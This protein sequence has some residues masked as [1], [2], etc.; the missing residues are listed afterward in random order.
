MSAV[1]RSFN[2]RNRQPANQ[3][4]D[5]MRVTTAASNRPLMDGV[6]SMVAPSLRRRMVPPG[7]LTCDRDGCGAVS[8]TR[9]DSTLVSSGPMI[10]R[11][12]RGAAVEGAS[13]TR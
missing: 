7:A 6:N 1:A 5:R 9:G 10:E 12:S 2:P 3:N 11:D 8:A 13:A 4:D